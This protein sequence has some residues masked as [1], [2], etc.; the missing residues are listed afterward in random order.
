MQLGAIL[1]QRES[2]EMTLRVGKL[3]IQRI[4]DMR[5]RFLTRNQLLQQLKVVED[6]YEYLLYIKKPDPEVQAKKEKLELEVF[7]SVWFWIE[8]NF[9]IQALTTLPNFDPFQS[10][11]YNKLVNNVLVQMLGSLFDAKKKTELKIAKDIDMT[12]VFL[13]FFC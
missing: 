2:F 4:N 1:R 7:C 5:T 12:Q 10:D 13:F 6:F 9:Q 8:H 11:E 3:C